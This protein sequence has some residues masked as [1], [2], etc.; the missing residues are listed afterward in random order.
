MSSGNLFSLF[1]GRLQA[2]GG[3]PFIE[4]PDG[5]VI[6]YEAMGDATARIANLLAGLGVAA[7]DRVAVQADKSIESLLVYLA[8]LRL[9]AVYIPLNPAYTVAELRYLLADAEPR[10]F[11][12]T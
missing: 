8:C 6:T 5:S 12:C 1:A 2:E 4:R 11:V 7:G 3:R 9:G 10:L